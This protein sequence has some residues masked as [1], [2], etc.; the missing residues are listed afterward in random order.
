[1]TTNAKP[2]HGI[3]FGYEQDPSGSQG[4][5]TRVAEVQD[6]N[7]PDSERGVTEVT[8][9]EDTWDSY[10]IAGRVKR[11]PITFDVNFVESDSTHE[12]AST[13]LLWHHYQGAKFGFR[14]WGPDGQAGTDEIIGSGFCT[15]LTGRNAPVREGAEMASF[16]I[17]PTGPMK[18]DGSIITPA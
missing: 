8:P 6:F 9:H 11:G 13:G 17:Q 14:I 10:V 2:S 4:T 15:S 3:N 18:I 1:M 7:W 16:A 5:F 12:E